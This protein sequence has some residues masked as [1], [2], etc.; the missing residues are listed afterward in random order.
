MLSFLMNERSQAVRLPKEFRL[1]GRIAAFVAPDSANSS[2]TTVPSTNGGPAPKKT[3]LLTLDDHSGLNIA[4]RFVPRDTTWAHF[5]HFR[6]AFER[7]GIPQ[8]IYTDGL[9]LLA[10]ISSPRY[11]FPSSQRQNRTTLWHLPETSRYTPCAY[12]G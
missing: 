3:L 7:F 11:P 12:Q 1:P 5:L 9:S 8:A 2:S 4:G 6:E 10:P